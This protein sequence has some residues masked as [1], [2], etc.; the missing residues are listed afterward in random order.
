MNGPIKKEEFQK[1]AEEVALLLLDSVLVRKREGKEERLQV[2]EVEIYEGFRDKASHAYRG[3][4]ERSKV[5]FEEG[6]V[7]YVYL[8]YGM[9]YML[10]VVVDRE[11]Y[12]SAI[13]IR[14][15]GEYDGPGKLT[16]ALGIDFSLNKRKI[17][18]ESD[19]WFER[20]KKEGKI[21]RTPRVGIRCA[22][23]WRD[24]PLRFIK[25]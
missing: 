24:A 5:M 19:L 9:Y 3:K 16:R 10:N 11:D 7:F 25:R 17:G 2:R 12:P 4:T 8:V 22:K 23:K 6:G 20:N 15:A 18:K 13:L 21:E 14:T 1:S